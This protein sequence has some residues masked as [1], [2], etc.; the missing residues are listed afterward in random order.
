MQKKKLRVL[1]VC[2]F[3]ILCFSWLPT[4][5]GQT[6]KGSP[7]TITNISLDKKTFSP[8]K[9]ASIRIKYKL[10]KDASVVVKL[11]NSSDILVRT[12]IENKNVATGS[13]CVEWDGKDDKGSP[14]P[15]GAYIYT[16]EAISANGERARYDHADETGGLLLKVRKPFLDVEKG[17]VIYVMPKAGMVRIRAGIK[18]GPLLKTIIDWEAREAGRNI[19]RWDGKDKSGL[20][21]LFKIPGREIY[22]FAYTLPDNSII[23]K[24]DSPNEDGSHPALLE[25]VPE[26][27]PRKK[28]YLE[29]K[30]EHAVHEKSICHEPEFQVIFPKTLPG[31]PEG[32]PV[33]N[34]IV[35]VKVIIS[36]RDRQHLE[37]SR[38]EVMFFVDTVF[39]FEDEEGFTPFTYL[40]DTSGLTEGEHVFTVN[41][42][43]YDDH[44]GVESRKVM[45]RRR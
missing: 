12:L 8:D 6:E 15:S 14:V 38:F 4:A 35:P 37:S 1:V 28:V 7:L 17:E 30:Y 34:G 11:Y 21:D 26:C 31:T 29:L 27:R 10:S 44:C 16:I 36:E 20:I 9:E 33:L 40:W 5:Y 23:V 24:R 18:N 43:S 2:C 22:V 32:I 41:I 42:L 25:H 3:S 13:H 39:I 19:E 45:I